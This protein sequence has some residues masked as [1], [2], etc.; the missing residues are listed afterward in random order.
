VAVAEASAPHAT[1]DDIAE[2]GALMGEIALTNSSSDKQQ[3]QQQQQQQ[4]VPIDK[5]L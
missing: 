2:Q 1:I 3:Q 5:G 4:P